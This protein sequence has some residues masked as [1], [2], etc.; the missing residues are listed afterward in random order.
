MHACLRIACFCLTLS[1]ATQKHVIAAEPPRVEIQVFAEDSGLGNRV[2]NEQPAGYH[3]AVVRELLRRV[4]Q[5]D[6][7]KLVPWARGDQTLLRLPNVALFSTTR[8]PE[9]EDL[10]KWVEPTNVVSWA[11]Y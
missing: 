4:K 11:M 9:R 7:I 5:V 2:E 1:W 10:F 8:T 6:R 3:V